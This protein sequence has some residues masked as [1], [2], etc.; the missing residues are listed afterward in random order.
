MSSDNPD[1][2]CTGRRSSAMDL[3]AGVV[4]HSGSSLEMKGFQKLIPPE[5][6]E[7]MCQ[8]HD[9]RQ[10]EP[11]CESD[12]A[13]P[14]TL[15]FVDCDGVINVGIRD[16][17]GQSPLL[18]CEKNLAVC[19]ACDSPPR[20]GS[21]AATSHIMFSTAYRQ[22][23]LGDEGTY[24][25]FATPPG[26]HDISP[27]L[28]ERL[29]EILQYAGP[30]SKMVLSSSWR[31]PKHQQR[32][33]ALEAALSKYSQAPITFDARTKL[34][35]DEPEKRVELIGD[36][37]REYSENRQHSDRPLRVLVLEDFGASHPQHWNL[38]HKTSHPQSVEGVEACLRECSFQPKQT[39]V[40]LVHC[41]EEWTTSFGQ[42]VQVGT[43][44]TR[45]KV[46]EA[47]RFLL[48]PPGS[49]LLQGML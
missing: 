44:L 28:A 41:Y 4:G 10:E 37:V 29:A 22:V 2:P 45:A 1:E 6:K 25:K 3:L 35:S 48:P 39:S 43:G 21:V 20:A 19:K 12:L 27:L 47:E 40:K 46:C 33:E 11:D 18:L 15:I 9:C 24:A 32:V 23:G 13:D 8:Q 49:V 38:V 17:P 14:E 5:H 31:K 16:F 34:G 42:F 30:H 26:S 36:F 7:T